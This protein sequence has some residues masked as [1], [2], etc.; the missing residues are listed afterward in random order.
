MI[1]PPASSRCCFGGNG[2]G[3]EVSEGTWVVLQIGI[4]LWIPA[5]VCRCLPRRHTFA[6]SCSY[7]YSYSDS[8]SYSYYSY[9]Y[10]Y[11]Y[12]YYQYYHHYYYYY[13]YSYPYSYY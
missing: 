13:D 5:Q 9:S 2:R 12:S 10:Y 7:S 3:G 8:D 11:Y 4:P 6:A 1:I